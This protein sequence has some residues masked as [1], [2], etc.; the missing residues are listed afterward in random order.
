MNRVLYGG[1]CQKRKDSGIPSDVLREFNRVLKS[2]NAVAAIAYINQFDSQ[3]DNRP[4]YSSLAALAV[5]QFGEEF[6]NYVGEETAG[7]EFPQLSALERKT[8][9]TPSHAGELTVDELLNEHGDI[10]L[11][12][13][14]GLMHQMRCAFEGKSGYPYNGC[15]PPKQ[16]Y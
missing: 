9:T 7:F 10:A 15:V 2:N 16:D 5:K 12:G 4:F 6:F 8:R 13:S 11:L 3:H 1:L 14:S